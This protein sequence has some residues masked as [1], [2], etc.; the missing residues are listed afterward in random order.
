M[1]PA[2]LITS[3][4]AAALW[5]LDESATAQLVAPAIAAPVT[6]A[7]SPSSTAAPTNTAIAIAAAVTTVPGMPPVIDSHNLYS[8]VGADRLSSAVAGALERIYVPNRGANTVSVINP[9]TLKEIG[10]AHV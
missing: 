1:L 7:A 8:E 5:M 4:V 9:T 10:R 3:A 2:A 6:T